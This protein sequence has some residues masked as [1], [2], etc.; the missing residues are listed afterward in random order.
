MFSEWYFSFFISTASVLIY[1]IYFCKARY[2]NNDRTATDLW[3]ELVTTFIPFVATIDILKS[4]KL[5]R[6]RISIGSGALL[7][8]N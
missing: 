2:R 4:G 1:W 3:L 6:K 5:I 7:M 8:T